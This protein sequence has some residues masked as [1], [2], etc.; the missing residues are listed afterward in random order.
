MANR[1]SRANYDNDQLVLKEF[2]T[3]EAVVLAQGESIKEGQVLIFDTTKKKYV[4]YVKS[5]HTSKFNQE[6]VRV[7]VYKGDKDINATEDT[8]V[9][10]LR[11]GI[12]NKALLKGCE[13]EDYN[14]IAT[15]EKTNIFVE[16]VL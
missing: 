5:T 7:R 16:E 3:G 2:I 14:L 6:V 4:K 8:V 1:V 13:D 15:L 12:V 10:V 9:E 11:Q